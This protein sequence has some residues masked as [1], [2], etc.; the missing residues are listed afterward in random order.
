MPLIYL[1]MMGPTRPMG[2][3]L[4]GAHD[5]SSIV[6]GDMK[7]YKARHVMLGYILAGCRL[8]NL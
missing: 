1:L 4:A 7:C 3:V 5:G 2:S 6:A 8:G